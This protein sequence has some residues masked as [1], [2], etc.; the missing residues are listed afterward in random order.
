[1]PGQFI[2][3]MIRTIFILQLHADHRIYLADVVVVV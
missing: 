2:F 1:M 3:D